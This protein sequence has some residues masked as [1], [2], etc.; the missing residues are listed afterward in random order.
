MFPISS[1]STQSGQFIR[2]THNQFSLYICC[3]CF[4]CST[5][6]A[7]SQLA[8]CSA[9]PCDVIC[10]DTFGEREARSNASGAEQRLTKAVRR[11]DGWARTLLHHRRWSREEEK[12]SL[13]Q[14]TA[15]E[16]EKEMCLGDRT[17][18]CFSWRRSA[19]LNC[20]SLTP[21]SVAVREKHRSTLERPKRERQPA[22]MS[23]TAAPKTWV[24]D[25]CGSSFY[26]SALFHC[27][28]RLGV[29]NYGISNDTMSVHDRPGEPCSGLHPLILARPTNPC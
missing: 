22:F 11:I 9:S 28:N 10:G 5:T 21:A 6:T 2:N 17:H 18:F 29:T 1:L 3:S 25:V 12:S 24:T 27:G 16:E 23:N 20:F 26:N 13:W 19:E 14:T 7:S 15:E 4:W 8:P